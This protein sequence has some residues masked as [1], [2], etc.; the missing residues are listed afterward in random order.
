MRVICHVQGIVIVLSSRLLV[1]VV[2]WVLGVLEPPQPVRV[3]RDEQA[4]LEFLVANCQQ[5]RS[6]AGLSK[7][8]KAKAKAG[9]AA[10]GADGRSA[11]VPPP[12]RPGAAE[13]PSPPLYK[14]K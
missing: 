10:S 7:H 1:S 13:P 8:A 11:S 2:N 3:V 4:A 5:V 14:C 9:R 6:Y 12:G